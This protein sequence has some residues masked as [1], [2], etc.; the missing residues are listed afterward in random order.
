MEGQGL[1]VKLDIASAP[2]QSWKEPVELEAQWIPLNT[3]QKA[4]CF[5]ISQAYYTMDTIQWGPC[6]QASL[7]ETLIS[8][9]SK[10]YEDFWDSDGW[11]H[12]AQ[13]LDGGNF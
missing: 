5:S 11:P 4:G 8:I 12:V 1:R 2:S 3:W 9:I 10:D 6:I 7:T 13:P